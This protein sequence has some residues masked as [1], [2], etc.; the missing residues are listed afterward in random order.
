MNT[1]AANQKPKPVRDV[2]RLA[3]WS[4]TSRASVGEGEKGEGGE[5]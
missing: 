1:K 2:R 5:G 3:V 4:V